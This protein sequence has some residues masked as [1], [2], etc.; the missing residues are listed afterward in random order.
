MAKILIISRSFPGLDK[1]I[2]ISDNHPCWHPGYWALHPT[3][4][5]AL[6]MEYTL[7]NT[8]LTFPYL[9]LV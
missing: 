4:A 3:H 2:P 9:N 5:T 6:L 7:N 8:V 1:F